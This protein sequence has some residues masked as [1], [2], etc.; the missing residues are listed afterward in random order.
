MFDEEVWSQSSKWYQT[1]DDQLLY[2]RENG[3][4]RAV[5]LY[6]KSMGSVLVVWIHLTGLNIRVLKMC[7]PLSPPPPPLTTTPVLHTCSFFT[8]SSLYPCKLWAG[9]G[10]ITQS[11]QQFYT[12]SL[13]SILSTVKVLLRIMI[14]NLTIMFLLCT[15]KG[16]RWSSWIDRGAV[17]SYSLRIPCYS[18][19]PFIRSIQHY[20]CG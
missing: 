5:I 18:C 11:I 15:G 13:Q 17:W 16:W 4:R 12:K 2:S 9:V 1:W 3:V 8:C 7:P 20:R 14:I 19:F 10:F 6:R